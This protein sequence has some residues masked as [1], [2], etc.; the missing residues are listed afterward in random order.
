MVSCLPRC[1]SREYLLKRLH[2]TRPNSPRYVTAIVLTSALLLLSSSDLC[3]AYGK[4]LLTELEKV[5]QSEIMRLMQE[6]KNS[7]T[8]RTK[9][10]CSWALKEMKTLQKWLVLHGSD[11]S[12]IALSRYFICKTVK[13]VSVHF[14]IGY[15]LLSIGI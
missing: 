2:C 6:G 15:Q 14:F 9:S 3:S 4:P 8:K 13:C 10:L 5:S 12:G 7:R 1:H 11:L